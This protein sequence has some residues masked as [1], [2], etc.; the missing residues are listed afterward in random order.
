MLELFQI[1]IVSPP[2]KRFLRTRSDDTWQ[3]IEFIPC[4]RQKYQV[5]FVTENKNISFICMQ[6]AHALFQTSRL[7]SSITKILSLTHR[8]CRSKPTL[9]YRRIWPVWTVSGSNLLTYH[10]PL[11][12]EIGLAVYSRCNLIGVTY[13]HL[14]L[15][16]SPC[17]LTH[18]PVHNIPDAFFT[19]K[20]IELTYLKDSNAAAHSV[21][22]D[23]FQSSDSSICAL[24]DLTLTFI[25]QST[26]K[27][28]GICPCMHQLHVW[29]DIDGELW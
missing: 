7:I 25:S 14:S 3:L 11:Q 21:D 9:F 27:W 18:W 22:S 23:I 15:T 4:E 1:K 17:W 24:Q 20:I 13:I 16:D 26:V 5:T 6:L 10:L 8:K 29:W 2:L 12:Q 28:W 19:G